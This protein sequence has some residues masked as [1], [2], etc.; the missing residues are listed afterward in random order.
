METEY[1][2]I[3]P[4]GNSRRDFPSAESGADI[5]EIVHMESHALRDRVCNNARLYMEARTWDK[6]LQQV[7]D[8]MEKLINEIK[9]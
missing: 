5:L 3:D 4:W 2:H 7:I 9:E 8:A 1:S 6:P